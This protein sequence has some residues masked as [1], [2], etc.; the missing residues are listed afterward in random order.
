MLV[1]KIEPSGV[2][3]SSLPAKGAPSSTEWQAT[4]SAAR[5]TYSPSSSVKVGASATPSN[6]VAGTRV[7]YHQPAAITMIAATTMILKILTVPCPALRMASHA[8]FVKGAPS[9]GATPAQIIV[10]ER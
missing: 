8:P 3:I 5:A 4:Q 9:N 7:T 1:A 6:G 2:L 10:T